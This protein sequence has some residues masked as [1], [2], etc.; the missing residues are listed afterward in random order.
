[1][2][3]RRRPPSL[4]ERVVVRT[5][6]A[7]VG[8]LLVVV[9]VAGLASRMRAELAASSAAVREEQR[10]ANVIV[11]GVMR[12]LVTVMMAMEGENRGFRM[13]FEAAGAEVQNALQTYLFRPLSPDQR[14][15][16]ELVKEEHRRME[17]G[18]LHATQVLQ[19]DG[20]EAAVAA[21]QEVVGHAQ[22]LLEELDRFLRSRERD[23]ERLE[24]S[25]AVA[26]RR[27]W[28]G[29]AAVLLLL[30]GVMA[31]STARFLRLRVSQPLGALVGAAE[32][33]GGGALDTRV[34][35]AQ[36]LEFQQ[37]ADAF[38]A[39]A[40]QLASARAD[41][42]ERNEE[43]ESAL[44][45]VRRAQ[46]ELVQSEK[47]GAVGRMTAGLAH[48]LNNPLAAVLGFSELLA[49][50]VEKGVPVPTEVARGYIQ[51]IVRD[52][53][54]AR[55]LIRSLLQ[56]TRRAGGEVGPVVLR[57]ALQVAV[58][59]RQQAFAQAGLALVVE[60]VP[61]VEVMAEPQ[62]LQSV[63]LNI[64]NNAWDALRP[65]GRGTLHVR[66]ALVGSM[67]EVTFQDDGPGFAHPDRIFEP[68]FT[69]KEVGEGTGLGL[70]LAERFVES[71]G[72]AI[73]AL[74]PP[75]GG[76]RLVVTLPLA[77]EGTPSG[78]QPSGQFEVP[79][80]VSVARGR[81]ILVV[82]DEPQLQRLSVQLLERIGARVLLAATAAEGRALLAE[83]QVDLIVSDVKMPAESGASF[84]QWVRDRYPHLAD[85][86]LFV[87]GDVGARELGDLAELEPHR[88]LLKPFSVAEYLGRVVTVLGDTQ[89]GEEE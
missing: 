89:E 60:P 37:L 33:L 23:L 86:F 14:V 47:L 17:V 12:Q 71:F 8:A 45:Q 62:K 76:A 20:P 87:T 46:D 36:D 13:P 65:A 27:M 74:N 40:A 28:V 19:L 73:R 80:A 10:I 68:F 51:P 50:E 41:L 18:A 67:V 4:R 82:E 56:Y 15:Q 49:A 34:P 63:F 58:D 64:I 35:P 42:E 61:A 32:R 22:A 59:L 88:L 31:L 30:G 85:R 6:L 70:S 53:T 3:G 66:A 11:G 38:N 44:D 39:M 5:A 26:F 78:W 75:S 9:L 81:Q 43:L 24:T 7:G 16:I 29:G 48:E 25:Q 57:E 72:G 84:Y 77:A 83:H 1:M 52:A 69:T 79:L 2:S 21:R 54:R 55:L